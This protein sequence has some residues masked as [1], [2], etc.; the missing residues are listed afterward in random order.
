MGDGL[1]DFGEDYKASSLAYTIFPTILVMS[2]D[3]NRKR[4]VMRAINKIHSTKFSHCV[5]RNV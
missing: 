5:A 2:R 4:I 1:I 3:E